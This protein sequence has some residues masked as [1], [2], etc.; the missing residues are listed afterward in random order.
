MKIKIKS[1]WPAIAW[2]ILST[3]AFFIPGKALPNDKWLDKIQADKWIHIGIFA[4]MVFLWSVPLL[5]RP[6][7]K[8]FIR[9]LVLIT[10]AFFGY[11]VLIELMQH[12]FISNRSF[13][14]SDIGA[15]AVGCLIGFFLARRQWKM[16]EL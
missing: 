2:M 12:F 13:G 14:W 16:S 15:D 6:L 9:L 3:I 8:S 10:S 5:Y 4:G 11:G 1:Y 7:Q